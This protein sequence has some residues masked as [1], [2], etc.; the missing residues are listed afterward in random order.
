MS[1]RPKI[2]V[3]WSGGKDSALALERVTIA[4]E[5]EVDHLHT[6]ID[7]NSGRVGLHG[8]K[9]E[10]IERQALSLKIPLRKLYLNASDDHSNYE[11]LMRDYYKSLK[12]DGIKHVLF[13]DIFLQDLKDYRDNM[14][15]D[16]GLTG[17]YPLW[18]LKTTDVLNEFLIK[19]FKTLICAANKQF[20]S[21]QALG[22]TIEPDFQSQIKPSVDPC[23]ENGEFHT[24]V[25]DG[26]IFSSPVAFEK[27]ET[28]EKSYQYAR[29][30]ED[31]TVDKLKSTFFFQELK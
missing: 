4:Q 6:V 2:S 23:G 13:G 3:S 11:R 10:L 9:E 12:A 7:Y 5:Y 15:N 14:M 30:N 18:H 16:A 31:G 27:A 25:Y 26:P 1:N 17:I 28:V 29:R 21:K 19:G 22:M 8:I 20:F 24:F